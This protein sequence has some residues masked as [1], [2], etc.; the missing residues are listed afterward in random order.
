MRIMML[1]PNELD[2]GAHALPPKAQ[3]ALDNYN[4]FF[5]SSNDLNNYSQEAVLS[6]LD[7]LFELYPKHHALLMRRAR[8]YLG[9]DEPELVLAEVD[10]TEVLKTDPTH[11]DALLLRIDTH[12]KL[13]KDVELLS[14]LN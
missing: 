6:A 8:I 7:L 5:S 11:I 9:Q 3:Q 1:S 12:H 13:G 4:Q 14:D 2:P 10:L